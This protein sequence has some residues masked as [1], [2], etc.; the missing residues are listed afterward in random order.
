MAFSLTWLPDVLKAAGLKVAEC[1]G[2]Q[3]RG[4]AEMGTVKGVLCHHTATAGTSGNMPTLNVLINGRGDLPGPLSQLGLGRDG[5]FYIIAAGRC[6]H[7]GAGSWMG[8]T[9][10]NSSFI[11][12]EAEHP[13]VASV[14][15][16]AV[17]VDAY[18][19]GVA[20]ILE[21]IGKGPEFCAGHKEYA[22][23]AGRKSDPNLDMD[24]FRRKVADIMNGV[25]PAPMLIPK[26]EPGKPANVA[27]PT[28][29]RG[30][31]NDPALVKIVQAKVGVSPDGKFGPKTEAAIRASQAAQGAVPDGIV[32]PKTWKMIDAAV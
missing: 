10:G 23:P 22:L 21:H 8:I 27:R 17:Q 13:G 24:G 29:R 31:N 32:G 30:E 18:C 4:R 28:L 11:G 16:P 12:I 19:R 14:P 6:N 2:W 5:T 3:N 1:P 9:A 20:A 15:W 25:T 26:V 7:A